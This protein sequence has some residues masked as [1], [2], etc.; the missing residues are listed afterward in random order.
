MA[1]LVNDSIW[2]KYKRIVQNFIDQDAG[3]QE[4]IWLKHIQYPLPFG[5]DDDE[6]KLKLIMK[7]SLSKL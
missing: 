3:L 5:E 7:E 1:F 2:K 4:V 6:N